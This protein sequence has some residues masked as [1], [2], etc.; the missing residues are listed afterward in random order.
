MRLPLTICQNKQMRPDRVCN[1]RLSLHMEDSRL[2]KESANLE[3]VVFLDVQ[4]QC[5]PSSG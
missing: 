1:S 5:V 3:E 4:R 2:D